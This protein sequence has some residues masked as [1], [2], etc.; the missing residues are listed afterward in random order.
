VP[1][2]LGLCVIKGGL[3]GWWDLR[4]CVKGEM[5]VDSETPMSLHSFRFLLSLQRQRRYFEFL[6]LNDEINKVSYYSSTLF[7]GGIAGRWEKGINNEFAFA[8]AFAFGSSTQFS[9]NELQ[10]H[11]FT[12]IDLLVDSIEK[13]YTQIHSTPSYD[14]TP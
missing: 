1:I 3:C 6:P 4:N 13:I 9:T 10:T 11:S 7:N 14:I 2:G 5:M 8:F 12:Y